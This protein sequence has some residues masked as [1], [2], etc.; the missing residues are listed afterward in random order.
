MPELLE[1]AASPEECANWLPR[2]QLAVR[3]MVAYDMARRS[4]YPE[5]GGPFLENGYAYSSREVFMSDL[6]DNLALLV[7][8]YAA[9]VGAPVPSTHDQE[10]LELLRESFRRSLQQDECRRQRA[11]EALS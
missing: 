3:L 1:P 11:Q 7:G 5:P 4:C 9:E 8:E 6:L 2:E 10:R